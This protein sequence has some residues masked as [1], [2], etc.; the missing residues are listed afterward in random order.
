M[1][2]IAVALVSLACLA[3]SIVTPTT[4]SQASSAAVAAPTAVTTY[5][6]VTGE[7]VAV[8]ST[9]DG[10]PNVTLLSGASGAG[11][12]EVLASAPHLY[13]L[14]HYA[15]GFIGQPLALDLFDVNTL[16]PEGSSTTTAQPELAVEYS[17]GS[18][19]QLPPGLTAS[20]SG[21]V[22]VDDPTAFGKALAKQ[23]TA[24][25]RGAAS[26]LFAGIARI[27]PAASTV[28]GPPPGELFTVTVKGFDRHG[29]R[30]GGDLG[31]VMN[32][33]DLTLFLA[34]QS[35][36]RGEF[37]VSVP[38]G[39]YSISSYISTAYPDGHIDLT[40]TAAPEVVVNRDTTVILDARRGRPV[41]VSTPLPSTP[42]HAELNYQ[43]NPQ[44]GPTFTASFITFGGLPLYATPTS[45]VQAGQLYFYP[46]FR[47][48]GT[49]DKLRGYLYDLT[50]SHAGSI[51]DDP[52]WAVGQDELA[53]VDAAYHSP[54][55]GRAELGLR[56]GLRSWQAVAIGAADTIVAP[57]ERTEYVTAQPDLLWL[58]F[59]AA[60]LQSNRGAP[61]GLLSYSPGEHT[62][63]TWMAQPMASGIQQLTAVGQQCPMCRTGDTLNTILL[64]FTDNDGHYMIADSA[65]SEDLTLYQ[66]GT[67]V[68]HSSS[69]IASFPLSPEPQTY[70]LVYDAGQNAPWWPTSTRVH[71]EWTFPS[72]QRAA[73]PLPSGW[74]CTGKGGGGGGR[75]DAADGKGGGE[76]GCSFE[77][78]LFTR[79][80]TSAG[81]DDVVP[82]G[83]PAT[84]DVTVSHQLGATGAAITAF[85]AQVSYDDGQTWQDVPA[86]AQGDGVFRLAYDQPALD[87]TTGYASLRVRATDAGGSSID[88]TINRAYPLAVPSPS[89]VPTTPG[90]G[91]QPVC[92][93][94]AAPPYVRCLAEVNTAV[95]VSLSEPVGLAPSDIQSAYALPVGA[96]QGKTVAIV[97]AYHN[98]NAEADLAVYRE[99]WGLPPCTSANGCLTT[100]SQR[101]L[102]TDLPAPSTSWGLEIALDLDAVSAACPSC[103]ILLVEADSASLADLIPAVLTAQRLGADAISN[104]YGSRGEFSGEQYLERYYRQLQV[105]FVVASGDYGYG[106]GAIL[107]GG[108]SYPSASQFAVAVGG[109]ALNRSDSQRGWSESAWDGAT[110]GCSAYIRKPGWQKDALCGM[111][112][113]AD[114]AAVADPHTGLAVYDTFGYDGWLQVGGTSLATPV[115]A[116]VYAM[117][118]DGPTSR[119]A[120][121]LYR[122]PSLLNDVTD[123]ANGDNCAGSYLCTAVPGY[124]GPT[125]LGTPAGLSAFG[126]GLA[127]AG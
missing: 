30:A 123:G 102:T 109:T 76:E 10:R 97:D 71:T 26:E 39:H 120:S 126:P 17:P 80:S 34:G 116:S 114:V 16:T 12:F 1:R 47:L 42:V 13:V 55:P 93:T 32:A 67:Q 60:D 11:S 31:T 33:D 40:L 85:A 18:A 106:N 81:L 25:K 8:G 124:D 20:G 65:T 75:L 35:F 7:R 127:P 36:F 52:A 3:L 59:V 45:P 62:R 92:A 100:V 54:V 87:R 90:S 107:V 99:H 66:G 83:G 15:A 73:D 4:P 2:R 118:G 119:Y 64:P 74:T 51:P 9:P 43:R 14:P 86:T 79:Y 70:K 38:A 53:T 50:S 94:P 115:I 103:K 95:G 77:P 96:G 61:Q 113:V 44:T 6:L 24:D 91:D 27:A 49:D 28:A 23:W 110:S 29:R 101:G 98:P 104:S 68:G 112:T 46:F 78:L 21:R 111:R 22:K 19:R 82:A 72:Q 57:V 88:Q 69:G 122:D 84:V 105:P 117:A 121:G 48:T 41:S 58:E 108:V 37:A 63:A 89:A 5:T 125:G 56:L